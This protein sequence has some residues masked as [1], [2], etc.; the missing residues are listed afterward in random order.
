M[1]CN[2][3]VYAPIIHSSY[4]HH[5]LNSE[6]NLLHFSLPIQFC[7]LLISTSLNGSIIGE[8]IHLLKFALSGHRLTL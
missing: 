6:H 1:S 7:L 4:G 8:Q 3:A 2:R 5:L